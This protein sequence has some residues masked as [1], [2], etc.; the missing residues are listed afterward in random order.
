VRKDDASPFFLARENANAA[1]ASDEATNDAALE[2]DE[3]DAATP[4]DESTTSGQLADKV[5]VDE[6]GQFVAQSDDVYGLLRDLEEDSEDPLGLAQKI[7]EQLFGAD[8]DPFA[9][10]NPQAKKPEAPPLPVVGVRM[11]F[12]APAYA[13]LALGEESVPG[14]FGSESAE[15]AAGWLERPIGLTGPF[16]VSSSSSDEAAEEALRWLGPTSPVEQEAQLFGLSSSAGAEDPLGSSAAGS[17]DAA[18]KTGLNGKAAKSAPS[19]GPAEP[20]DFGLSDRSRVQLGTT[21]LRTT[22]VRSGGGETVFAASVGPLD[23]T[24]R[25]RVLPAQEGPFGSLGSV[26]KVVSAYLR[27]SATRSESAGRV[28]S[29]VG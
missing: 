4:D 27:Q 23:G 9:K 13:P 29:T 5:V 1:A 2:A 8:D 11:D 15:Q 20:L 16:T 24:D 6:E 25:F 26:A 10:V 3:A 21:P 18:A 12:G 19:A 7:K 17:S 22:P 28:L 14:L